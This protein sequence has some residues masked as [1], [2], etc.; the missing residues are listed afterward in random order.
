VRVVVAR[1]EEVGVHARQVLDLQLDERLCELGL[2]PKLEGEVICGVMLAEESR[3]DEEGQR[4]IRTSLKF[5][6]A[7]HDVHEELD[8]RVRGP[9]DLIE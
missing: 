8:N 5:K 9:K 7:G 1:V 6:L 2:V 3:I 4:K